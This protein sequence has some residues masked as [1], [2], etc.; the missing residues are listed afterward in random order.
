MM[1]G[2]CPCKSKIH[3]ASHVNLCAELKLECYGNNPKQKK[4]QVDNRLTFL[5]QW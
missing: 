5:K 3:T 1:K 2:L 4:D